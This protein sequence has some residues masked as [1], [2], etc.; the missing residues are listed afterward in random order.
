MLLDICD[1]RIAFAASNQSFAPV[2][3]VNLRMSEGTIC[4]LVGESGSGKS[5]SALALLGLLPANANV[6]GSIRLDGKELLGMS[7]RAW[8]AVRG[9]GIGMIFQEP[10]TAL[11]PVLSI[12]AQLCEPLELHRSLRGRAARARAIELLAQ[13]GLTDP[14]T[15]LTQF[16]HQLSGGMRQRVMI[17]MAIAGEP[18]LLVAD[19]P[20][21][22]L[23]VTIQ[24]QILALLRGLQSARGLGVLLITHD[25]GV[26][27]EVADQVCVMYSGRVVES[28]P[29]ADIFANPRHPYTAAL[30]RCT[31]KVAPLDETEASTSGGGFRLPMIAGDVPD[32]RHRPTGCAFHPRCDRFAGD[33]ICANKIPP[34]R[35][36]GLDSRVA[37]WKAAGLPPADFPATPDL[38]AGDAP[39]TN[40]VSV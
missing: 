4:A 2:E 33:P 34:L 17:A 35:E 26:V 7:P 6:S 3:H 1:L 38:S 9:G 5:L 22:A 19:E 30:L 24:A 40:R 11:N 16:P 31:P 25:L 39:Q 23:D 28:G 36:A 18:K 20:T 13:V 8:R 12:G 29:V 37:C 14:A 10:M 15:R 27:A 21:T 32:P